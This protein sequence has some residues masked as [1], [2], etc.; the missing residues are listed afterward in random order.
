[1]SFRVSMLAGA[2]IVASIG[3]V[4][5]LQNPPPTPQPPP[6]PQQQP[7]TFRGTTN[8]VLV[9]A[10]PHNKDGRVVEG[11]TA[12]DFQVL[13]DGK[14]QK[15]ESF[16]FVRIETGLSESERRDPN[17]TREMLA[18]AAD[19][20]NRVFVVFL[21]A[22]H[23][24]VAGSHEIRRPLVEALN[25]I[26]APNDLFGVVTQNHRPIDLVLGR[27]LMSVEEQLTKYWPWG[28][29]QRLSSDPTDPVEDELK[30]C[31]AGSKIADGPVMRLLED[32]LIE[33]RRADRTLS[34]LENMV[35]YLATL[36]EARSM[37]LLVS[38][39]WVISPSNQALQHQPLG[40]P[41][42]APPVGILSGKLTTAR[43]VDGT[44]DTLGC[45][46]EFLRLAS[47]DFDRRQRDLINVANR[48]NVS[49]YPINPQGL[50]VFDTDLSKPVIPNKNSEPS[51]DGTILTR[52]FD[53]VDTRTDSLRVLA[54]NTGGV[55]VVQTNDLG[56]GLKKIVDDVSAYYLLGYYSTNTRNDGGI[57]RI[58]VKMRPAGLTVS[59]R[60]GYRAPDARAE[61]RAISSAAVTAAASAAPPGMD[62]ALGVLSR[63]RP[64]GDL[65]T[66]GVARDA[67]LQIVVELAGRQL[68]MGGWANG[69]K[70]Q[71]KVTG[72]AGEAVGEATGAIEPGARGVTV[73]VPVTGDGPWH[74]S[75]SAI[76]GAQSVDDR[77]DVRV[78]PV[79][80]LGAPL[81]YRATPSPRSVLRPVADFQYRRTERAHVEWPMAKPLDQRTARVL[82]RRGQPLPL[83]A[84][85]TER[86]VDG[87]PQLAVD[88]NLAPLS[89]GDYLIEVTAGA[90]T[91]TD[92]KI[93]AIRVVR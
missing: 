87:K 54:E 83:G 69:G 29:R 21:D 47:I 22:L 61:A 59:A 63:L 72:A 17:N 48:S 15:V 66:Y 89:E 23:V 3:A 10:Y 82:D 70:V 25:R 45:N 64:N 9:D 75:A 78:A 14:P 65:F 13:E 80:L 42:V 40:T 56:A 31:F 73:R 30:R 46:S 18:L 16:E 62:E 71:V 92:Q 60:R 2:A 1:M 58:E 26:I 39:G 76:A 90:G 41:E 52:E 38:A 5:A 88:V 81:L 32:V 8:L 85:V 24:T 11:L 57:R 93:V 20:H 67:E 4:A 7:P 43:P 44:G 50:E 19:P 79:S 6:A 37:L 91:I 28:E 36:R 27:R 55:A 51:R 35:A 12:E 77:A 53:R 84:T 34:A 86:D 68:E 33:R 74:V 49:F